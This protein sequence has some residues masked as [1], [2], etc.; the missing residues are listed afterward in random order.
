[1]RMITYCVY[2]KYRITPTLEINQDDAEMF[3]GNANIQ[4]HKIK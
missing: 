3:T 2:G 4:K 1:M